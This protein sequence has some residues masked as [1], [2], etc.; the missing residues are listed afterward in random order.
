VTE[1]SQRVL[2]ADDSVVTR[3]GIRVALEQEGFEICAEAADAR[4]AVELALSERPD[5]CILDIVMPEGGG[6]RAVREIASQLPNAKMVMLTGSEA[7]E[8]V[9]DALR[10]GATGYV[11]KDENLRGLTKAVRELVSG[12]RPMSKRAVAD[13]LEQERLRHRRAELAEGRGA[14]L[15]D[16]EWE[17]LELLAGGHSEQDIALRLGVDADTIST[18]ATAAG[19]KLGVEDREA[20]LE[21]ARGLRSN[22]L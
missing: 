8:D 3:Y 15:T 16:H 10:M 9:R 13:L 14:L 12:G 22:S 6:I 20:A 2:I 7:G 11:L 18:D 19:R 1:G 17:V 5:I 4:A 21:L